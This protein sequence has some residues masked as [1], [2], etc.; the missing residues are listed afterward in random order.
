MPAAVSFYGAKTEMKALVL[1]AFGG[2]E[3]FALRDIPKPAGGTIP[4]PNSTVLQ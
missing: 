1:T 2:P 3:N 4:D